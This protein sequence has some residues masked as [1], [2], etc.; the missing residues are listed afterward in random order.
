MPDDKRP[1]ATSVSTKIYKYETKYY[2]VSSYVSPLL[3]FIFTN[4]ERNYYRFY[5]PDDDDDSI[6]SEK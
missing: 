6:A 4:G 5:I 1:K 3:D 2:I